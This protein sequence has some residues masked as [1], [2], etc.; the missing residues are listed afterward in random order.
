MFRRRYLAHNRDIHE[1]KYQEKKFKCDSCD[2]AFRYRPALTKHIKMVHMG[3]EKNHKCEECDKAYKTK[4][5]LLV[6]IHTKHTK[7]MFVKKCPGMLYFY[8]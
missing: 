4:G 8:F 3:L 6:H 1:P 5:Q 2:A 7:H